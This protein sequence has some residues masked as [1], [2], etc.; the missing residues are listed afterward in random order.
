[1]FVLGIIMVL[2]G[3]LMV[4]GFTTPAQSESPKAHKWQ[5][6]SW[7]PSGITWDTIGYISK[8]VERMSNGRL[9]MTPSA[10]GAIVPVSEQL[11]AVRMGVM[12]GTFIWPG[13]FP[14]ELPVAFM[15]GDC[16]AAPRTIAELRYLYESYENGKIMEILRKEYAKYGVYLVG[17]LYWTLDNIMISKSPIRGIADI[18]G[19][20]FRTSELIALQLAHLGAGTIWTPGSEIYSMLASG[21]VDAITFSH[22]GDMVAMG[23]HDVTKYWI[24][25][26]TVVG[27]ASDALIVN[28]DEWKALP[29][30]LKAIVEASVEVGSARNAFE[31]EL[32]IAQ[33]WNF[34]KEK[35]IEVIEWSEEDAKKLA[36][37]ARIVVPKK[38]LDNPAF[39]EIFKTVERWALEKG[40]W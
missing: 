33:A 38:Y 30:D 12:K 31:A 20:K 36:G 37:T 32:A 2:I 7:L 6:S 14:G 28:M 25:F 11:N 27:P 21:A 18:K 4:V 8:Y 26:P 5:P 1:M 23:F 29:D 3:G 15:H 16:F 22:A 39:A 19:K 40:Y 9:I 24:K 34:V 35:G 13:Y 17:N 10:P